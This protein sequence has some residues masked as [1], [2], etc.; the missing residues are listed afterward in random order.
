LEY[1]TVADHSKEMMM[2]KE[3]F[4][5]TQ[6]LLGTQKNTCVMPASRNQ[7][8]TKVYS[9]ANVF[10]TTHVVH[11]QDE[12]YQVEDSRGFVTCEYDKVVA[13]V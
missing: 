11:L 9:E 12:E 10:N 1:C 13:C 7:I 4:R 2:L 5:K 3:R 8:Q 6:T